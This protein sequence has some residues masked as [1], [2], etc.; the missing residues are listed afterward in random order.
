MVDTIAINTELA[1][2]IGLEQAIVLSTIR[3][4]H[5]FNLHNPSY[6]RGEYV[7]CLTSKKH[8][9]ETL[10]FLS[11]RMIQTSIEKLSEQGLITKCEKDGSK[12]FWLSLTKNGIALF[13]G[14]E[15]A[16]VKPEPTKKA[17]L[18]V[19]EKRAIL[20]EKCEPYVAQYGR[21]MIEAFLNYWGE[22]NGNEIRCEVAKRKSGA[23]EIARRLATWASKD[24]NQTPAQPAQPSRP[25]KEIWEELGITREQYI[26]MHKK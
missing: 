20:R 19:E 22:A 24:Y 2:N 14:G 25:K 1:T 18:S 7:W 26:E 11:D 8:L 17:T 6:V 10:P 12:D 15:V 21:P 4:W 23:F 13:E 9:R 5:N 3:T 16:I